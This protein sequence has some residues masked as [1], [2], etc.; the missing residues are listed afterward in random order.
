MSYSNEQEK[1]SVF[2]PACAHARVRVYA[3]VWRQDCA[4]VCI[5]VFRG[6][7]HACVHMCECACMQMRASVQAT[8]LIAHYFIF[9]SEVSALRY[10]W[11]P[12]FIEVM[13]THTLC[14]FAECAGLPCMFI[15]RHVHLFSPKMSIATSRQNSG[16]IMV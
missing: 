12:G 4:C 8:V 16:H 2:S 7:V 15:F 5:C 10:R 3:F 13:C 9:L 1:V 6:R 14:A 11:F